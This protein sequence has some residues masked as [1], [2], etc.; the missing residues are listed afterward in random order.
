MKEAEYSDHPDALRVIL[1]N[2]E[3]ASLKEALGISEEREREL[4]DKAMAFWKA[5]K[6][7]AD[8]FK[9]MS[10]LADN[11]NELAL[12]FFHMGVLMERTNGAKREEKEAFSTA[13]NA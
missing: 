5:G 1:Y 12:M 7:V 11:A 8:A 2:P 4:M 13:T 10:K 6:K 9:E 3:S